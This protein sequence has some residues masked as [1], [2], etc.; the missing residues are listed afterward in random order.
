MEPSFSKRHFQL[1]EYKV[2]HGSL[3]IRSPKTQE[4]ETNVDLIC[5]GVEY[6]EMPRH[7]RE[8]AMKAAS[9][10]EIARLSDILNKQLKSSSVRIIVSEGRRFPIVAAGFKI[11][12]NDSDIFQSPFD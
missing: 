5:V 10:Q 4:L 8:F 6:F 1:W 12:E 3:L 9:V 11:S 2:S 7:L